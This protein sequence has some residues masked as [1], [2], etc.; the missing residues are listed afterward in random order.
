[1][2]IRSD[3]ILLLADIQLLMHNLL[4]AIAGIQDQSGEAGRGL[5]AAIPHE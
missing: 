1:M 5:M 4:D 3:Y 2:E